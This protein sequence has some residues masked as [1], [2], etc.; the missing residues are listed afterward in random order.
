MM[1]EMDL[2]DNFQYCGPEA[3]NRT[4]D[5]AQN[6]IINYTMYLFIMK[7]KNVNNLTI[8]LLNLIPTS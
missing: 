1:S 2:E 8:G 4:E 7:D 5:R 6:I 3:V